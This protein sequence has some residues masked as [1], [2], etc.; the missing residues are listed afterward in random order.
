MKNIKLIKMIKELLKKLLNKKRKIVE[1]SN[2]IRKEIDI[3]RILNVIEY[4]ITRGS[5]LSINDAKIINLFD[6]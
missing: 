4:E 5:N 2:C 1:D 6:Y 3:L